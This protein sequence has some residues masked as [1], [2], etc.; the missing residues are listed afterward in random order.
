MPAIT[1]PFTLRSPSLV[2]FYST[3]LL[4]FIYPFREQLL[5]NV[6]HLV[7]LR[8]NIKR[9]Y[10]NALW[11][12]GRDSCDTYIVKLHRNSF[13]PPFCAAVLRTIPATHGTR[14][15]FHKSYTQEQQFMCIDTTGR[16]CNYFS[17]VEEQMCPILHTLYIY[18]GV[19]G[20]SYYGV[21]SIDLRYTTSLLHHCKPTKVEQS[22]HLK[23]SQLMLVSQLLSSMYYTI[24]TWRLVWLQL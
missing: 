18:G 24:R 10:N 1:P 19:T 12:S 7:P 9:R 11:L 20:L 23:V 4:S 8:K 22:F 6:T 15:L 3:Q 5:P 17:A 16:Q 14:L 21:I 2:G 13:W